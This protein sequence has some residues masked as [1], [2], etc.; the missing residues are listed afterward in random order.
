[1]KT[2]VIV[3][4]ILLA[5]VARADDVLH[6]GTPELDP[7]TINALGVVLPITGDDNFNASVT[8]RYWNGSLEGGFRDAMPLQHVH[9]EA[10]TGFTVSPQFAG[11]IFDLAPNTTYTIE[12]HITDPDGPVDQTVQIMGTTRGVPGDPAH[13]HVVNVADAAALQAALDAAQPGDVITLADGTYSGTFDLHASGTA[14]DPIVIRGAA[15]QGAILDG[16]GCTGCNVIEVYASYVHVEQLTIQHASRAIRFQTAGAIGDVVRRVHI[17]DVQ[18]AIGSNPDQKDFYIADNLLEGR[19]A[20]PC[21]YTSDDP[22][23]NA[24]GQHGLHA[25]D[26]GIHVEGT[27]HVIAHNTI[28]GF[29][30]AM[31]TEQDGAVSIDFVGNDVLSAYDNGIELDGSARNTRALRN[32]FTN[33]F[34]TLSF[35]P[36]FGG[37]AYAIRNVLVNVADEQFKLHARG[38]TPTVGA[39]ILHNTIVRGVRAVQVSSADVPMYFTVEDNLFVGPSAIGDAHPVRWDVP[40]VSTA[41][42]DYD[43]IFPDG[44][45]EFGYDDTTYASFAAMVAGGKFEPHGVLLDSHALA[46]DQIGTA[47][48]TQT[49]TPS[50][51][52]LSSSSGAID[53]GVVFPNVDDAFK[54]AAPDLGAIEAGCDAPIYGVRPPGVDETNEPSGCGA[55][56]GTPDGGMIPGDAGVGVPGG[57]CCDARGSA[58]GPIALALVSAVIAARRRRPRPSSSSRR[59]R[60]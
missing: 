33:T 41:T 35:Q 31:K 37:P 28:S 47:D 26:D 1:M 17:R 49:L 45:M 15:S 32:R 2:R 43:G 22:A 29:G 5:R 20:W 36:I 42:I 6:P 39:V 58:G 12:L 23:C 16:N 8:V 38:T 10:V 56:S 53:R 44:M 21:V 25:N 9:S 24:G 60:R 52:V 51:P 40:S 30:D 11:S 55:S 57:G 7:P 3:A 18:L 13:P 27:G 34:A 14:I 48:W 4:M 54:G 19:L 46:N 50:T 59:A